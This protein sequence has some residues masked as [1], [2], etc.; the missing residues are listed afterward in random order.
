M[1]SFEPQIGNVKTGQTSSGFTV[2]IPIFF[3]TNLKRNFVRSHGSTLVDIFYKIAIGIFY[4]IAIGMTMK[5]GY[6]LKN[7]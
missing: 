4:K 3:K 5:L 6:C 1:I 7:N 2:I